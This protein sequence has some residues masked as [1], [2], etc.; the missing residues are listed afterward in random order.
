MD[1]TTDLNS[2]ASLEAMIYNADIFCGLLKYLLFAP[3]TMTS[4]SSL[5][6]VLLLFWLLVGLDKATVRI[7]TFKSHRIVVVRFNFSA[8]RR[9]KK[10]VGAPVANH[11]SL[12]WI[13]LSLPCSISSIPR[14]Q[15]LQW[16]HMDTRGRQHCNNCSQFTFFSRIMLGYLLLLII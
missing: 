7:K 2:D 9:V 12:L 13:V 8:H 5:C 6:P 11:A 10:V 4:L 14:W 3:L 1:V 15:R 16:F